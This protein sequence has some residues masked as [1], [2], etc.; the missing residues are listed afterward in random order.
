MHQILELSKVE[1][2]QFFQ[3]AAARSNDIKSPIIIEKDF[4]VCWCLKQIFSIPE[5]SPYIT[6]KGGTSLSKCY[7]IINRFSEDCDIT[8]DKRFLG[9]NEDAEIISKKSRNQRDKSIN[10]LVNAAKNKV[11]LFIKPLLTSKFQAEL[12][13][14]FFDIQWRIEIDPNDARDA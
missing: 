2:A 9:I 3:E 5:I 7:N 4:W 6:F 10:E 11:F 12:S 1:R 13:N 14:Y 8:L